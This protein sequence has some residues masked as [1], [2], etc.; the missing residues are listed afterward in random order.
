M[1]NSYTQ[2][3][4]L[5]AGIFSIM[6]GVLHD[7]NVFNPSTPLIQIMGTFFVAVSVYFSR[8]DKRIKEINGK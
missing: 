7:E 2:G 4:L 3:F 1:F 8:Q 5:G 6:M